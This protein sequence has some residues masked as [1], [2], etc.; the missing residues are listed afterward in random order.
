MTAMHGP[1]RTK[2][3]IFKSLED[4][5][6]ELVWASE[7]SYMNWSRSPTQRGNVV[8]IL[9]RPCA[10]NVANNVIIF[11]YLNNWIP[12]DLSQVFTPPL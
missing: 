5:G 12:T 6:C 8:S 10:D 9:D 2:N 4:L 1:H 7:P 3:K 11:M